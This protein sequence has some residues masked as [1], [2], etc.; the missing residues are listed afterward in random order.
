LA[1]L[2]QAWLA[3]GD[4][5]ADSP[6]PRIG[7]APVASGHGWLAV[8][9]EVSLSTRAVGAP[10][11]LA[12]DGALAV[13]PRLTVGLSQSA[14]ALGTVDRTGGLCLDS[15]TRTCPR[16]W[17]GALLDVRWRL[18]DGDRA[19]TALA[20]LGVSG[21][22]PARP[23][24]RLGA[25]AA[26]R[27]GRWWVVGQPE[28]AISLGQQAAG[29]RSSFEAPVWLGRD[30]G[31]AGLWLRTGVRGELAGFGEKFEIP[32]GL[33]VAWSRGRLRAGLDAGWPQLLGPQNAFKQRQGAV[34]IAIER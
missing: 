30:L 27:H 15:V 29:N 13:H 33:G 34:W 24:V 9:Y 17:R 19:L 28:L 6:L 32:I 26:A 3:L 2:V 11:A 10:W 23:L 16:R 1:G 20:R 8:T 25:R 22:G 4:A 5:R 31:L 12:L 7:A 18:R 14:A 21:L